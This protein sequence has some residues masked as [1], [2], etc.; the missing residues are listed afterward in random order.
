MG[1]DSRR[2]LARDKDTRFE[3]RFLSG[4]NSR[5]CPKALR[6]IRMWRSTKGPTVV[7]T[8]TYLKTNRGIQSKQR[9]TH[10]LDT[11]STPPITTIAQLHLTSHSNTITFHIIQSD[12]PA[13]TG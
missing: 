10:S 1:N 13:S 2:A 7:T 9:K 8:V 4:Y 6:R 3:Q 5:F 12:E 11:M